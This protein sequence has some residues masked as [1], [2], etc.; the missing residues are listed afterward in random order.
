VDRGECCG[1]PPGPGD[2]CGGSHHLHHQVG[3][4]RIRDPMDQI[5]IKTPN[6]KGRIYWWCL[7]EFIDR[8]YCQ[9][10]WYFRPLL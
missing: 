4:P 1:E 7:V 3:I 2:C 6:P 5:T 9:S 8:K 10:C